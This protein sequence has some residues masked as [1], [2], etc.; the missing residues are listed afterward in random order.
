[1]EKKRNVLFCSIQMIT[2]S[3]TRTTTATTTSWWINRQLF[4][5][6]SRCVC[7]W[8]YIFC[9]CLVAGSVVLNLLAYLS[10][11]SN[12]HVPCSATTTASFT[13]SVFCSVDCLWLFKFYSFYFLFCFEYGN[14]GFIFINNPKHKHSN[15]QPFELV[16][17]EQLKGFQRLSLR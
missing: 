11:I 9:F 13:A 6:V 4:E 1:M 12:V 5:C 14:V 8:V 10:T 3:R 7:A 17:Q 15:L 2:R 16:V